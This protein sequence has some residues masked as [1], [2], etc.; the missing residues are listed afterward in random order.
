MSAPKSSPGS[1]QR[2]RSFPT[3]EFTDAEAGAKEF[4]SSKSRRYSYYQ[5]AKKRATVYEDVTVDVQPD[6][7]R[8]LTQGWIY[9]FGNGPGGYPQ[10]WT[11]AKSSNWH[12]FL[13]PNEEWEQ[14]I[15]R[16]NSAVVHQV[17]L[18]LQNAKRARVYD[19]WNPSWL[20]FIERNLGAWMHAESGM[21]LHVFTSIQRSAPT[22]MINNAVAVSAAHKLR[23]AQDLALFNLDLA[24]AEEAFDGSAHKEVWQSAPEWQPTR[25]AV[26]RLTAIGD[27]AKLLFCTNIVF[28]QLV[29]SLFRTELIMQVA[30]RNGDYITPT[31]VGTGEY[32]YD[33]DLNYTRAL[34]LMLS[35][36]EEYG[37]QN[38]ALFGEW[39][40]EWVPR[41]LDAARG[42]QPI[43]S[44]PADKSVTFATSLEAATEKFRD[45]LKSI[46]VDIPEELNQ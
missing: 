32:D 30:A 2:E 31:I 37:A 26:E 39:L 18:C 29:G 16:N 25:E 11:A 5:P 13:D 34:F 40:S 8:H 6:P 43:W 22:N 38:R 46:E 42:L 41:C 44:Q 33:R 4:P 19:G 45:V 1:P 35:R 17:D 23:F 28:E 12:A 10:E 24:E 36:D 27:W 20:K 14:T 3:I 15:F 7:E 9:G 21:G